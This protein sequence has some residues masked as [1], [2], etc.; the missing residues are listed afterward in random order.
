MSTG[1]PARGSEARS[2]PRPEDAIQSLERGLQI[3]HSFE[4]RS[5]Q[6]IVEITEQTSISRSAVRR[7]AITLVNLGYLSV[8]GR[9]YSVTPKVLW[10]GYTH[11][12]NLS[13]S[14]ICR[15]HVRSIADQLELS[16]SIGVMDGTSVRYLCH[17]P[18]A[19]EFS[20]TISEGYRLPAYMTSLGRVIM[21]SW[22]SVEVESYIAEARISE[23]PWIDKLRADI[24]LTAERGWSMADQLIEVG[25]RSVAVPIRD[26]LGDVVAAI[27]TATSSVQGGESQFIERVLPALHEQSRLISKQLRPGVSL[28]Q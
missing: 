20:P 13:L 4:N 6:T 1:S 21:A 28:T 24:E 3:I 12:Q 15:P 2:R 10:L 23:A 22:S 26:R 14:T 17:I 5:S 7:L 11:L 16:A 25:L 19:R 8:E 9:Q 27:S 18:S